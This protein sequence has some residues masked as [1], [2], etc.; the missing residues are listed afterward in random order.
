MCFYFRT[1]AHAYNYRTVAVL[2]VVAQGIESVLLSELTRKEREKKQ[3]KINKS[4]VRH[5]LSRIQRVFA[6]A[7]NCIFVDGAKW[8]TAGIDLYSYSFRNLPAAVIHQVVKFH[9]R[10]FTDLKM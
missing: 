2:S 6:P 5:V 9:N 10:L 1:F 4:V 7:W 3:K 8:G